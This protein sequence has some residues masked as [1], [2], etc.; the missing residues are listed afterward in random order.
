MPARP[1]H[2][3]LELGDGPGQQRLGLGPASEL[4]EHR[5]L[6]GIAVVAEEDQRP[7]P[8][9]QA[10]LA[11]ELRPRPG[12]VE[13]GGVV[14]G[15]EERA[16]RLAAGV[17]VVGGTAGQG[18]GFVE[19][20]HALGDAP[21]L[22]VGQPAVGQRLRLEVHVAEVPGAV[23]G[24][25]G[26]GEQLLG[27]AGIASHGGDG[28]PALFDAGLDVLEQAGGAGEPGPSRRQVSHGVGQH[29]A[30]PG[31]GHRRGPGVP[32]GGEGPHGGGQV[33]DESV[34][35]HAGV[36][37]VGE[38]ERSRRLVHGRHGDSLAS[39]S[40]ADHGRRTGSPMGASTSGDRPRW[41]VGGPIV[42]CPH[43][44]AQ[45]RRRRG[46][47]VRAADLAGHRCGGPPTAGGSGGRDGPSHTAPLRRRAPFRLTRSTG[48]PVPAPR[49]LSVH[50]HRR[51]P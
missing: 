48:P 32:G 50:G 6:D 45:V 14:A 39:R 4:Q 12:P 35:V 29:V 28:H 49:T 15:G 18:H 22:Y 41:P 20:R 27:V 36:G 51:C 5:R 3:G 33:G 11:Q 37:L 26:P 7:G 8:T 42:R 21:R 9:H 44:A 38:L 46:E 17:E 24:E 31:A 2:D 25:L 10:P 19:Q 43:D 40:R 13:V 47:R 30:E 34:D 1:L 16:H 23:E